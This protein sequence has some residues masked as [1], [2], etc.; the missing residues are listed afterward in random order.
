MNHTK[1][2]TQ[3]AKGSCF[4]G[5]VS[6]TY[7]HLVKLFGQPFGPSTDGKVQAEWIV[8]FENGSVATVYDWKRYGFPPTTTTTWHVGGCDEE[9]L[10]N[11]EAAVKGLTR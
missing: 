2:K 7:D 9:A 8:K 3:D 6:A 4:Q 10:W 11:I 1:G 5:Y